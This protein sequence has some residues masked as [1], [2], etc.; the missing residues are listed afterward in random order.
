MSLKEEGDAVMPDQHC[1]GLI[2]VQPTINRLE[3][4]LAGWSEGHS[5]RVLVQRQL[6]SLYKHRAALMLR[7]WGKR[8]TQAV[9]F[10]C[11]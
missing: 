10:R 3:E 5:E 1:A 7:E 9:L 4:E 6:A 8:C 11:C 2:H